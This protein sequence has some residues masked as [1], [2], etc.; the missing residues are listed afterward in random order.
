MS[1]KDLYTNDSDQD[2][3][4]T[5]PLAYIPDLVFEEVQV[6]VSK[7]DP[8][9]SHEDPSA[10]IDE[11]ETE[12]ES[13]QFNLFSG[14][15]TESKVVLVQETDPEP[16]MVI[17]EGVMYVEMSRPDSYYF[18][19]PSTQEQEAY[20][21][22]AVSGQDI[23]NQSVPTLRFWG[24]SR[25]PKLINFN[26]LQIQAKK[27]YQKLRNKKRPGKKARMAKK[28]KYTKDIEKKKEIQRQRQRE[29][30]GLRKPLPKKSGHPRKQPKVINE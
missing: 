17:Q 21:S 18:S 1:R 3:K 20:K 19:H 9:E 13:F 5:E 12:E 24:S 14:A 22:S 4:V 7:S 11:N 29:S 27:E 28:I 30:R 26:D 10:T 16:E 8:E 6:E 23:I 25:K 15:V 2:V